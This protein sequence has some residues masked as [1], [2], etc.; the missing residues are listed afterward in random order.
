[1]S[2]HAD[3]YCLNFFHSFTTKNKLEPY[4]KVC[5]NQDFCGVVMLSDGT[6]ISK[7]NQC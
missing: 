5:K 3:F 7:F 6:K 1:M 2:K 4:K